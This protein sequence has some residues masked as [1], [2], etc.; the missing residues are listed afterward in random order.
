MR[1]TVCDYPADVSDLQW[2]VLPLPLPTPTRLTVFRHEVDR[3]CCVTATRH[4]DASREQILTEDREACR[5]SPVVS[6]GEEHTDNRN[7]G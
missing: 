1:S 3:E 6:S 7:E 2:E 4:N 5:A